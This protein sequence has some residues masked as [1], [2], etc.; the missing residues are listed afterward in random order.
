MASDSLCLVP[1]LV[2]VAASDGLAHSGRALTMALSPRDDSV[3]VY[4]RPIIQAPGNPAGQVEAGENH[5]YFASMQL[6]PSTERRN[7]VTDTWIAYTAL[8]EVSETEGALP[9]VAKGYAQAVRKMV[10]DYVNLTRV[11][12]QETSKADVKPQFSSEHYRCLHTSFSLFEVLYLPDYDFTEVEE[13][14]CGEEI[15]EWLNTHFIEPSTEEG[16]QLSSLEK[17]WEDENFWPYITRTTLRGL[18]EASVFFLNIL[19]ESHPSATLREFS[20]RLTAHIRS[21]P[22]HH[23]HTLEKDMVRAWRRWVDEVK[24]MRIQLDH[25]PE[26]DR[27]DGYENWWDRLSQIVGIL[28][29][30]QEVVRRVCAELGGDWKEV[31]AAWGVFVDPRLRRRRL[32]ELAAMIFEEFPP[33]PTNHEDMIH[34]SLFSGNLEEALEYAS[35]LDTWLAAHL[36]DTMKIVSILDS[37]VDDNDLSIRDRYVLQYAEYL[38][39]DAA[40]WRLTPSYFCSCG[41]IGK[42]RAD[43]VLLRVPLKPGRSG[44]EEPGLHKN[45]PERE[46]SLGDT[47]RE[48]TEICHLYKR[49]AVRR[50]ICRIGAQL[51]VQQK[52][53]AEAIS[54]AASGEDWPGLGRIVD[55][56]LQEYI[57]H[58]PVV[59]ARLVGKTIPF[60]EPLDMNG[61]GRVIFI[62][63]LEFANRYAEFHQ[64]R[65]S[66][67]VT[68]AALDLIAMFEQDVVPN[69]WWAVVLCDSIELLQHGTLP[70]SSWEACLLMRK[71]EEIYLRTSQGSGD[72]YL[73]IITR[74][75]AGGEK[76]ALRQLQ[77]VR[78]ALTQYYAR[79]AV[80]GVGGKDSYSVPR[81]VV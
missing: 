17:P 32:Q 19:T 55:Q 58:G 80:L 30:R 44:L 15:M 34:A 71:L 21:Q 63:R 73:P 22:R 49:E 56:I 76:E 36:A 18:S 68:G 26:D 7:F 35:Q 64:R 10:R 33:D 47:L 14:Q 45:A 53:F 40:L 65:L 50:T 3:A 20:A 12:W 29:G 59:F 81:I 67:D 23:N 38:R 37:V 48:I 57:D 8:R 25:V 78:L 41:E 11:N 62:R 2:G 16:V 74:I 46:R 24:T 61:K 6:A 77:F 42:E 52:Q 51:L 54:F 72:D 27:Y 75:K 69:S 39:S 70:F 4:S 9:H 66:G 1:P 28:E 79:C 31:I 60:L 43:Q 13:A 5:V